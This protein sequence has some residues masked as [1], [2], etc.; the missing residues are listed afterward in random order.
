MGMLYFKKDHIS[1]FVQIVTLQH[2]ILGHFCGGSLIDA[3]Y[4]I[5]AAHCFFSVYFDTSIV[6]IG[7]HYLNDRIEQRTISE[8]IRHPSYI[9]TDGNP[10]DIVLLKL[11][12]SIN[13]MTYPPICL[14][15]SET[16]TL[17]LPGQSVTVAGWGI[18]N[19]GIPSDVLLQTTLTILDPSIPACQPFINDTNKQLCVGI[20]GGGTGSCSVSIIKLFD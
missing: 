1:F 10:N 11:N 13:I 8:V 7:N 19:Q 9:L 20:I 16:V 2:P 3:N 6:Y 4:V 17:E 15:T 5:S 18:T 14:P 12:E